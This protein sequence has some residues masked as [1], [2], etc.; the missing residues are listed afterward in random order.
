MKV[1]AYADM[2]QRQL[3]GR[4]ALVPANWPLEVANSFVVGEPRKTSSHPQAERMIAY[5]AAMPISVDAKSAGQAFT[6]TLSLA[7]QYNLSAYSAAYLELAL[8]GG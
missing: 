5:L 2:V 1:D 4:R 7:R 3:P 6:G 8:D